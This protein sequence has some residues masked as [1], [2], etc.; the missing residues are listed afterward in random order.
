MC[1]TVQEDFCHAGS[2]TA[3]NFSD[4]RR[5]SFE[6]VS[7]VFPVCLLSLPPELLQDITLHHFDRAEPV[8]RLACVSRHFAATGLEGAGLRDRSGRLR[9]GSIVISKSRSATDAFSHASMRDLEVLRVDFS[10]ERRLALRTADVENAILTLGEKLAGAA[11]LRV[12]TV[13]LPAFDENSIR[14]RLSRSAWE[15]LTRGLGSLARYNQLRTLELSSITIKTSLAT[16]SVLLPEVGT[17]TAGCVG[18]TDD[19]RRSSDFGCGCDLRR[20]TNDAE[21]HGDNIFEVEQRRLRRAASE[22]LPKPLGTTLTFLEAL[23]QMSGLEE[24][25][26]TYNEIFS[27]TAL[28]LRPLLRKLSCLRKVDLTRNCIS[29][30]AMKAV[31]EATPADVEIC[32]DGQQTFSSTIP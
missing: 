12:L 14:L 2:A 8:G 19:V 28:L 29:K 31:K 5:E 15:A 11:Q 4:L 6:S 30:Q 9:V 3:R 17:T 25:V 27:D 22:P 7:R 10:A 23:E 24:L 16:L 32:G 1:E 21:N 20:S 13:R 26:L 18:L